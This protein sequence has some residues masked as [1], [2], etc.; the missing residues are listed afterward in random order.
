[1]CK[2]TF[3]RIP[4][5]HISRSRP[6]RCPI[7]RIATLHFVFLIFLDSL[8]I[9][10]RSKVIQEIRTP[11]SQC[12]LKNKSNSGCKNRDASRHFAAP[13]NCDAFQIPMFC[14]ARPPWIGR[15]R[16]SS[17]DPNLNSDGA[18]YRCGPSSPTHLTKLHNGGSCCC[19]GRRE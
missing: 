5:F 11:A 18:N 3:S 7:A 2:R 6:S 12:P 8:V 15:R 4:S 16:Q 14:G 19:N 1:M 9:Q 10:G 13:A 17:L